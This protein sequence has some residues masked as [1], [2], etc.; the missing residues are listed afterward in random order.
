MRSAYAN[1]RLMSSRMTMTVKFLLQAFWLCAA[2][3]GILKGAA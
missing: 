2:T 1:E 3:A